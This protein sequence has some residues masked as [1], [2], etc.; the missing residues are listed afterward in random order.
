M[1]VGCRWR[2]FLGTVSGITLG[3]STE[4]KELELGERFG[5][6]DPRVHERILWSQRGGIVECINMVGGHS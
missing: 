3:A 5:A 4:A 2:D 1:S 6:G